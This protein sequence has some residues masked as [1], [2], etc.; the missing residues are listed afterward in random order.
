MLNQ[1]CKEVK[2]GQIVLSHYI[3]NSHNNLFNNQLWEISITKNMPQLTILSDIILCLI[4]IWKLKIENEKNLLIS[5]DNLG[6]KVDIFVG[7]RKIIVTF[8]VILH[9]Y[10]FHLSIINLQFI[11]WRYKIY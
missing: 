9:I 11:R 7:F 4:E 2:T 3:S 6:A 5:I 8:S 1:Q 10:N